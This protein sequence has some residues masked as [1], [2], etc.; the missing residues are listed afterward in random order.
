MVLLPARR[1]CSS[2]C[3]PVFA[4]KESKR[5]TSRS[6]RSQVTLG[7]AVAS[8]QH[9]ARAA[10]AARAC[11]RGSTNVPRYPRSASKAGRD[12]GRSGSAGRFAHQAE[13]ED[14]LEALRDTLVQQRPRPA[15][16][17]RRDRAAPRVG[18]PGSIPTAGTGWSRRSPPAPAECAARAGPGARPSP[19][20]AARA[21]VQFPASRPHA[22]CRRSRAARP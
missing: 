15:M 10:P 17:R 20:R 18:A 7:R 13:L 22:P 5:A 16:R 8:P 2:T 21:F 11:R 9:R 3:T 6:G 4:D 1:K 19:G 12:R 14:R